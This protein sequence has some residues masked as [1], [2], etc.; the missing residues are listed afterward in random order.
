LSSKSLEKCGQTPASIAAEIIATFDADNDRSF[1]EALMNTALLRGMSARS[2]A[3]TAHDWRATV[4][5]DEQY[6]FAVAL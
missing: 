5:E 6:C 3:S 2:L 4:D 1:I